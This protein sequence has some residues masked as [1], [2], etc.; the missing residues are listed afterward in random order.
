LRVLLLTYQ[1]TRFKDRED[2]NVNVLFLSYK[3]SKYYTVT[4]KHGRSLRSESERCRE[5]TSK[6][7]VKSAFLYR[8]T[9]SRK[10]L[11]DFHH[12]RLLLGDTGCCVHWRH[13]GIV[14][15]R[16]HRMLC[17]LVRHPQHTQTGS[18]SSTIASDSING[19]TNTRCCR[20]SCMLSWWWVEV[21]PET[22]RAV[23]R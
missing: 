5:E 21:P 10:F 1:T 6:I 8:R 13:V 2:H 9:G 11:E 18:N 19:V 22:C 23:S 12:P 17:P 15:F 14:C 4:H 3:L 20:Y 7:R 16:W